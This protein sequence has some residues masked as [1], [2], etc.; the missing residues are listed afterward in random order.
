MQGNQIQRSCIGGPIVGSMRDQFEMRELAVTDF[1]KD[2]PR[3]GIA[4]AILL[5]RLQRSE[6]F[7]R[8]TGEL[9]IDQ[10]VLQGDNQTVP[11]EWSNEPWQTRSRQ[12]YQVIGAGD[13]QAEGRHV[14]QSLTVKAVE[15][16]VACTDLQYLAQPVGE[17]LC[18]LQLVAL[19]DAWIG[20]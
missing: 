5:F 8:S 18:M 16:L 1:V 14:V 13:G 19:R 17:R 6:Y 2:F 11:A 15:L 20:G 12:K 3:L 9:R 4:I 10:K 7:Q